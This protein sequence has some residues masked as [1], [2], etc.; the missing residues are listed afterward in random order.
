MSEEQLR[1]FREVLRL[2]RTT[3]DKGTD[4]A[5]RRGWNEGIEYAQR[6]LEKILSDLVE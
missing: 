2:G 5:F 1:L 3:P 4:Y 6:H